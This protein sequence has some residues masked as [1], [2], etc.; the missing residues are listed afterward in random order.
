[1]NSE[2]MEIVPRIFQAYCKRVLRNEAYNAH[3][4]IER[5]RGKE[6]SFSDL[7]LSEERQLLA[8]DKYFAKENITVFCVAGKQISTDLLKEALRSLP[9]EKRITI[10]LYYFCDLSDEEIGKKLN[11]PRSTVQYRRTSS[12]ELLKKFLEENADEMEEW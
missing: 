4:E 5:R 7:S 11:I 8:K 9:E 1:M 10:H 6:V 3:H 2:S 12:F